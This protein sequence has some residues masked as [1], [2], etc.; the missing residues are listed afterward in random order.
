MNIKYIIASIIL[1]AS[2]TSHAEEVKQYEG[3]TYLTS[4]EDSD[5]Y[6]KKG[7]ATHT[8]SIR[9]ML[10]QTVARENNPNKSVFYSKIS[11]S[12]SDCSQGFGVLSFYTPSGKSLGSADYVK[13]G[14]SVAAYVADMLCLI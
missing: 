8:K 10:M 11:I 1:T 13:G 3:W 5:Y 4:N 14:N 7:S 12:D 9:T 6:A 2:V